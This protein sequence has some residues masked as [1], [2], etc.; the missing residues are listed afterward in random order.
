[1]RKS[2]FNYSLYSH[3]EIRN[4]RVW[5]LLDVPCDKDDLSDNVSVAHALKPHTYA[6]IKHGIHISNTTVEFELS[7]S[8]HTLGYIEFDVLCNLDCLEDTISKYANFP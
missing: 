3:P 7:S 4:F 6:Y 2:L 5:H 8:L 1:M